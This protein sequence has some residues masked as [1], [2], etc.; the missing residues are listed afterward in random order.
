[1]TLSKP[2]R[3]SAAAAF[4][5]AALLVGRASVSASLPSF[6]VGGQSFSLQASSMIVNGFTYVGTSTFTPGSGS[7]ETVLEFTLTSATSI[8]QLKS[9]VPCHDV[10]NGLQEISVVEAGQASASGA[11]EIFASEVKYTD[12]I[13]RDW[14]VASPPT[15][16]QLVPDGT[17]VTAVDVTAV[18]ASIPALTTTGQLSYAAF[19]TAGPPAVPA[20]SQPAPSPIPSPSAEASAS[21]SPAAEPS[22]EPTPST[23]PAPSP[24]PDP[25]PAPAPSPSPTNLPSPIPLLA[26]IPS[27][28][29]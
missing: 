12:A 5:V 28:S 21:P 19:C 18:G 25:S 14:T 3:S 11:I 13:A 17:T 10:G 29:P 20:Q 24:S 15:A 16:G 6:T 23:I 26:P 7:P 2:A 8:E 9:I 4:A 1:M 27:P 22:P